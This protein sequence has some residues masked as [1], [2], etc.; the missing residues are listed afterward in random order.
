MRL[1]RVIHQA[2]IGYLNHDGIDS[3][4]PAGGI[5][6][7]KA[8]YH[9]KGAGGRLANLCDRV[10]VVFRIPRARCAQKHYPRINDHVSS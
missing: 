1:C 7:V 8:W 10:E 9:G 5:K 6:Q 2:E 3:A 4:L